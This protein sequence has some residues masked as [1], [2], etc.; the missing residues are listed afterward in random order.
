[1]PI[2]GPGVST[3]SA[4]EIRELKRKCRELE[5]TIEALKARDQFL[6]GSATRYTADLRVPILTPSECDLGDGLWLR[7]QQV[8]RLVGHAGYGRVLC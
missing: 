4:R 1:M 2:S 7:S 8:Q 6:C 3:E 5:Q